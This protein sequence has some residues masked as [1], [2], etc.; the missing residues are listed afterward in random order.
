MSIAKMTQSYIAEHPSIKDCVR[1][2]VVNFSALA[3]EICRD[4]DISRFDA[5]LIAC[6]RYARR[7]QGQSTNEKRILSLLRGAKMQV[8]NKMAVI[9]MEKPRDYERLYQLQRAV[10]REGHIFNLIDG[11]DAVVVITADDFVDEFREAFRGRI[12]KLSTSVVQITMTFD[13]RVESTPG[14]VSYVYSMLAENDVN[15]LEELSCWTELMLIVE[16]RDLSK[17]LRILDF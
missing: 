15:V 7:V 11:K 2:G 9:I 3:R 4:R 6:Q 12:K 10:K 14:V 1:K 13:Q 8:N 5:V 16:E 17:T